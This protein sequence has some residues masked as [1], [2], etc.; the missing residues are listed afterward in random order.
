MPLSNIHIPECLQGWKNFFV[1]QGKLPLP[2]HDTLKSLRGLKDL[3]I[4]LRKVSRVPGL[5]IS[6]IHEGKILYK[7]YYRYRNVENKV[8]VDRDTV[9]LI[10]SLTKGI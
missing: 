2:D 8:E 1:N 3:F 9:F 5:A 10:A 7:D 4:E 6:M